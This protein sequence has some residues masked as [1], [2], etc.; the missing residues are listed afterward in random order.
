MTWGPA[1]LSFDVEFFEH[2]PAY[3]QAR[4]TTERNSIGLDAFTKLL[5]NLENQGIRTTQFIVSDIAERHPEAIRKAVNRG[6]EIG[7]HTR[8][9]QELSSLSKIERE[10]ELADSRERLEDVTNTAVRGFRAPSF[11]LPV[12][13]FRSVQEAGYTY[14]SSVVPA[15]SIPG[16]YGGEYRT[17]RP[18]RA[19]ALENTA[20]ESLLEVPIGVLPFLRLP[21]TGAWLRLL[22]VRYAIRG[23]RLLAR[24]NIVPVLYF[25]P[26]AFAE[27]PR[28]EGIPIRVY[29][30][31]GDWMWKALERILAQPFEFVSVSEM[32][33]RQSY[34]FK[35]NGG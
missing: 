29:W 33:E 1:I 19:S 31:T 32:M 30:R 14:D 4:G 28:V 7:S 15:R 6:H 8:T 23:M 13:F 25:H 2:L 11:D 9:H 24:R 3:R 18:S 34:G 27:L 10:V 5:D 21:L 12:G 22:G 26:W 20:P 16:F 17:L 35:E